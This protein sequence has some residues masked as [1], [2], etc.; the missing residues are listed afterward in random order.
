MFIASLEYR[1]FVQQPRTSDEKTK[2]L[3][4]LAFKEKARTKSNLS[5]QEIMKTILEDYRVGVDILDPDVFPRED[6]AEFAKENKIT[7][8]PLVIEFIKKA[9]TLQEWS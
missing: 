9:K 4:D 1:K 3:T 7:N 2:K 8:D 5:Y 6:I